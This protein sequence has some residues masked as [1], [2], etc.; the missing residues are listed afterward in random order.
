MTF[1]YAEHTPLVT[2]TPVIG[3]A[4]KYCR[5]GT[6]LRSRP[7]MASV[8][9]QPQSTSTPIPDR[10]NYY[11]N[12]GVPALQQ[13]TCY[14]NYPTPSPISAS[15]NA[16][17]QVLATYVP[18]ATVLYLDPKEKPTVRLSPRIRI[19]CIALIICVSLVIGTAS[20]WTKVP[21]SGMKVGSPMGHNT[22]SSSVPQRP[23]VMEQREKDDKLRVKPSIVTQTL[24]PIP[25]QRQQFA[26]QREQFVEDRL[27]V[28]PTNK[29]RPSVPEQRQP[30]VFANGET[31][32]IRQPVNEQRPQIPQTPVAFESVEKL[33]PQSYGTRRVIY[34]FDDDDLDNEARVETLL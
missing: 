27:P 1:T 16:L 17:T 2:P 28:N 3:K 9:P 23:Q 13:Q 20:F 21:P 4:N 10:M 34:S 8:Y 29:K 31:P 26:E 33:E 22:S 12:Y 25:I 5:G 19:I 14:Y 15:G 24:P 6:N 18:G 32:E 7:S 11:G 30:V